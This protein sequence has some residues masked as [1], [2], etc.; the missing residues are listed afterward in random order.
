VGCLLRLVGFC[1]TLVF[2]DSVTTAA[3]LHG[4]FSLSALAQASQFRTQSAIYTICRV[5]VDFCA[6][7]IFQICYRTHN[8]QNISQAGLH[9]MLHLQG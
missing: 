6:I 2:S 8:L 5:I 3:A 9:N 7:K 4:S 1:Q